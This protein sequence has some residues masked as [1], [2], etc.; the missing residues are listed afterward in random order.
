MVWGE[1]RFGFR[2]FLIAVADK[3]NTNQ[4]KKQKNKQTKDILLTS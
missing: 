2:S 3:K 1:F 4:I